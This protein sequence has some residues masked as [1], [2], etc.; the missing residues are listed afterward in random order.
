MRGKFLHNEVLLAPLGR[1][2]EAQDWQTDYEVPIRIGEDLG[3]VDLVAERD[4]YCIAIEAEN[5][6]KRIARDLDKAAAMRADELWIV[7]PNLTVAAAVRRS[8]ARQLIR[9]DHGGLYV[10]TQGEALQRVKRCLPLFA[11]S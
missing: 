8:L 3:F 6:A 9:V 7:T 1:A 10:L 5:T 2:F 11:G 4:G